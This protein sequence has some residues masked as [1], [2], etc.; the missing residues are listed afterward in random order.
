[1]TSTAINPVKARMMVQLVSLWIPISL[2]ILALIIIQIQ[3]LLSVIFFIS[4]AALLILGIVLASVTV[5]LVKC[6]HCNR[7]CFSFT[8]PVW[9]FERVC[10]NCET[11]FQHFGAH[12]DT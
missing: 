4:S 8:F 5:F 2:L 11:P 6:P 3:P 10:S 9:P 7:R 12:R 1:M